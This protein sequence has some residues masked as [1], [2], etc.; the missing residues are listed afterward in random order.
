LLPFSHALLPL[1]THR[2]GV[3]VVGMQRGERL[4]PSLLGLPVAR[5]F[6][7]LILIVTAS[8]DSD[9]SVII[10]NIMISQRSPQ[11]IWAV[12]FITACATCGW[13]F[14]VAGLLMVLLLFL[15]ATVNAVLM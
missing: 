4:C 5:L 1:W 6:L 15:L 7:L 12:V 13:L 11:L 10:P 2:L 14:P 8:M 9:T 3:A